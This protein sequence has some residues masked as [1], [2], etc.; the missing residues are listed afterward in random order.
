MTAAV[1]ELKL[2]WVGSLDVYMASR[3]MV[4]RREQSDETDSTTLSGIW[5]PPVGRNSHLGIH[6]NSILASINDIRVWKSELA[7]C[8]VG[9]HGGSRALNGSFDGMLWSNLYVHWISDILELMIQV[10]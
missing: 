9:S 7:G 4:S 1:L 2:E 3:A 5:I 6:N 10:A 8:V